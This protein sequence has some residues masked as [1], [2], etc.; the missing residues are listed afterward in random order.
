MFSAIIV[1]VTVITLFMLGFRF[2]ANKGNLEQNAFLQFDSV[3]SGATVSI[4]GKPVGSN[5]PCKTS[6]PAGR[7]TV[8][9]WRYG[10]HT[11]QKTVDVNP[12]TLTWLNYTLLVPKI[13]TVQPVANYKSL[14][15]SLASP[16]GKYMLVQLQPNL[17]NY[18]L[19]DLSSDSIVS[20]DITIP[21]KD[22]TKPSA[23]SDINI[24]KPV[25]WDE[26]ERYVIIEHTYGNKTEWLVLDTQ[27]VNS[28]KNVSQL[29]DLGISKVIFIDN[30]GTNLY[31]LDSGDIRQL[32]L[33]AGT[34]SKPLVSNVID[35]NFYYDTKVITYVG[36]GKSGTN[37]RVVGLYRQGDSDP[38][39]IRT[40]NLKSD[41]PLHIATAYYFNEN[42]VAVSQANQVDIMS[43]SYPNTTSDNASSLKIIDSFKTQQNIDDLSFSP[44]GEY[45]FVQS[46]MHFASYDLEYQKLA[47]STVATSGNLSQLEW[48]DNNHLWSDTDGKL[49]IRDFDGT[50]VQIINPVLGGQD[51]TLTN[52]GRFLYSFNK[53]GTDYQ[54]QRVRM[55]LP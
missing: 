46:G 16:K 27:D 43:G 41:I 19:I 55:I 18:K 34:I 40:V 8:V 42:Y 9:M 47:L 33:N 4:D 35:F 31:V 54:L 6:I 28:T 12:G 48:L 11:W 39:V 52:N 37:Q 5:T 30:S 21:L 50:N 24:F 44:N 23:P 22:Y 29:F 2:D 32:D 14:S 25:Q 1:T 53:V 15:S 38:A 36:N 17:P 3:P 26:G 13:L 10:Y 20:T 7:H 49:S 45:V 51:V